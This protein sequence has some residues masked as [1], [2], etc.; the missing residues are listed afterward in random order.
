MNITTDGFAVDLTLAGGGN[1]YSVT[2]TGAA[3]MLTG[4][5]Q[6]DTLKSTGGADTLIG[7]AGDDTLISVAHFATVVYAGNQ[8][9]YTVTKVGGSIWQ[10][11]DTNVADGDD[12]TDTLIGV[13]TIQF[14]DG[15]MTLP[16]N[17][18]PVVASPISDTAINEDSALSF[19][20][21]SGTF[22]DPDG[23]ALTLTAT[24]ADGSPLPS[25]IT[26]DAATGTF[27]GTPPQDYNGQVALKVTADDGEYTVSDSFTLTIRAVNDAPVITSGGGGA[28]AS[29]TVFE[30]SRTVATVTAS[31]VDAGAY[32]RYAI[33]GGADA[34]LFQIGSRSGQVL[35]RAAPDY[36]APNDANRDGVYDIVVRVSD[37]K[38]S[39][40]QTLHITLGNVTN[41]ILKGTTA[42]NTITGAGGADR[43]YGFAG[44]DSLDGGAGNDQLYG[45]LGGDT[46]SGG[47]G[48]DR[49][50]GGE[51]HDILTGGLGR[52]LFVFDL[53][54]ST[55][56]V[57]T[58]TDFA[59]SQGDKIA[60]SLADYTGF[61]ETGAIT[62]DQFYAAAG[63]STAHDATDRLIYDTS[64][65]N[66]YYDADGAGGVDAVQ[67]ATLQS[68]ATAG[69]S[70]HDVL[71][72][73]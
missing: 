13:P 23:D 51:G 65:G 3:T 4:S 43:L 33:V 12:G 7:G 52:D 54:P 48:N 22:S 55:A 28:E 70:Y 73:A 39:D 62:A 32:Q 63:A 64:N 31:D 60:L 14:A 6:N 57:D 58:I 68:Y 36:E 15:T 18:A 66:L 45:G 8:A 21:P 44:N 11:V 30:N 10:V 25:W 46:L 35:F 27:S 47:L 5:A 69:F 42:D 9:D 53:P 29:Y 34:A 20:V 72:V 26:F 49:L 37:G 67:I 40:T 56:G 24:L 71:I 61:N 19:K 17:R 16:L 41:E 1:G 38:L 2:N 50:Y 59:H